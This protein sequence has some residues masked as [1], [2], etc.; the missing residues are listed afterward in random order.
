MLLDRRREAEPPTGVA[1]PPYEWLSKA[2]PS[3]LSMMYFQLPSVW[4]RTTSDLG[5]LLEQRQDGHLVRR[6]VRMETEDDPGLAADLFLAIGVDQEGE[7]RPVGS[8]RGLDD[9]RDE[10]LLGRLIEIFEVLTGRLLMRS[11]IEV[12]AVVDPSSSFQPKGKRYSTSI[13]FFA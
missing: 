8:G 9:P 11:E 2:L 12:A 10:M 6:Q 7:R 1:H 4:R 3:G 13:A 5:P